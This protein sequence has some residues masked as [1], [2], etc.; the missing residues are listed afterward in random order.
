VVGLGELEGLF[1]RTDL[2][3]DAV[4]LI[5]E[6]VAQAFRK[7]EREDVILVFGRVFGPA[8]GAGGVPDP[9][10]QG[11]IG[12]WLG[13]FGHLSGFPVFVIPNVVSIL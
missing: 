10:F 8:N 6:D 4:D 5:I 3:S 12:A 7:D 9:R 2:S 13:L 11:F 1:A